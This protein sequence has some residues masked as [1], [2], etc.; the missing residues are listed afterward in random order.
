MKMI[1]IHI[2]TYKRNDKLKLCV[3]S[4]HEA[5][6]RL[7]D[8]VVRVSLHFSIEEDRVKFYKTPIGRTCHCHL[9]ENEFKPPLFWNEELSFSN[10]DAFVYLTDDVI[11]HP[12]CL[13]NAW[14]QLMRKL[15]FDGVVG[16]KIANA[17]DG[18]PC[19]AAFGMIGREF[20]KRFPEAQVFC[21]EY[22]CFYL[23]MELQNF[24]TSIGKFI[25]CEEAQLDHAHPVFINS[26][27]D[28]CHIHHRRNAHKDK[29]MWTLRNAEKLLWGETFEII[30]EDE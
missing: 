13:V 5:R 30:G 24:S 14:E 26:L 11:L 15:S 3:E 18:Q 22:Y 17:T 9:L 8:V 7:Y 25:F 19:Q 20:K 23:D 16:F 12:H 1:D 4:I 29:I 10:A 2:P 28:E 27:P 6:K 21:P